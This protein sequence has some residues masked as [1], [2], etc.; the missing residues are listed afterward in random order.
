MDLNIVI[1]IG[2]LILVLFILVAGL[3]KLYENVLI[4]KSV[5]AAIEFAEST[6]KTGKDKLVRAVTFIENI[7]LAKI[8]V[9]L[10][11]LADF[12]IN[13]DKIVTLIERQI[14]KIKNKQ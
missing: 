12:L 3:T 13:P 6:G 14:T 9:W 10:R 8:P 4:K 5:N 7:V 2:V 1:N 11:P